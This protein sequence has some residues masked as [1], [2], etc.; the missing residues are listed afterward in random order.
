MTEQQPQTISGVAQSAVEIEVYPG[1]EGPEPEVTCEVRLLLETGEMYLAYF[2]KD[3]S[4]VQ[5]IEKG[6]SVSVT[7]YICSGLSSYTDED[8]SERAIP[9]LSVT[10]FNS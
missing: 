9:I 10:S 7:G 2:Y 3:F 6:S 8:G 4:R 1:S 5:T